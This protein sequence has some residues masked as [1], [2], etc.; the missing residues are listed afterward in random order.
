MIKGGG[1]VC[2][3]PAGSK[4]MGEES[5]S[6][7]EKL[8]SLVCDLT[9]SPKK[10]ASG[11][12]TTTAEEAKIAGSRRTGNR[13]RKFKKKGPPASWKGIRK[14]LKMESAEVGGKFCRQKRVVVME[15]GD[16]RVRV[17]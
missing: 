13:V 11:V 1:V 16:P 17:A 6:V 7:K 5:D 2:R 8:P 12:L 15:N 10:V 4:A 9:F 3:L 14:D